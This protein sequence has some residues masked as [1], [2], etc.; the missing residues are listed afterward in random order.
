M[1]DKFTFRVNSDASGEG[2]VVSN[3]AKFGDGYEQEVLQGINPHTER[4]TNTFSGYKAEARQL[5]DFIKAHAGVAILWTPPLGAEGYYKI[6]SYRTSPQGGNY[7]LVSM[8][9]EKVYAP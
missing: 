9:F 1:T 6:R 5:V 4:W 7:Y 2:G 8:E 3:F